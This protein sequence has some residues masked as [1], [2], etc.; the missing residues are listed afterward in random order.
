M[1]VPADSLPDLRSFRSD[2]YACLGPRRDA[3]FELGDALLTGGPSPS[4]VSLSLEAIPRRG[5][6][7]LSAALAH[8]A[9]DVDAA[10]LLLAHQP[11]A[12]TPPVYAVD[13]SGW[14]RRDAEISPGRGFYY[15]PSRHSA[16]QPIVAGWAYQWLA[17]L[18]FTPD[19][20][21][22]PV[23]VQRIH[24]SANAPTVAAAQIRTLLRARPSAAPPLFVFDA[25]YDPERLARERVNAPVAVLVRLRRARGFDA[26]PTSPPTTGRPRRQGAKFV[27]TDPTT[28][29]APTAEHPA[30]DGQYGRVRVRAWAGLHAK[31]PN[32]PTRGTHKPR[33][34]LRGTVML[35]EGGRLP[36]TTRAPPPWWLWYHGATAAAGLDLDLDLLWRAS[37]R[38]FDLEHPFRFIKSTRP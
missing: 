14:P 4:P 8:G 21:T 7:S 33:P 11:L 17:Q 38:R 15:H 37:V 34:V 22:A 25:G 28:W 12:D 35:V 1:V 2:L 3:L 19:S 36:Q 5:W 27:C 26:D 31:S 18:G 32:P 23:D 24:P 6:G 13:V 30:V 9:V 29:P 20:W 10:R 16:G